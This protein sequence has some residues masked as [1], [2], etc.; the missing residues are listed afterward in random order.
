MPQK[1]TT[2]ECLDA[3]SQLWHRCKPESLDTALATFDEEIPGWDNLGNLPKGIPPR[4]VENIF[5]A[6][7][8]RKCQKLLQQTR[9]I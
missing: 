5:R 1:P 4:V 8:W 6:S 7:A 2:D 3:L 9:R